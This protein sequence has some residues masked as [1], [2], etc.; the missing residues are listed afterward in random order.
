[1]P[2]PLLYLPYSVCKTHTISFRGHM[3]AGA[4]IGQTLWTSCTCLIADFHL[5]QVH[6]VHYFTSLLGCKR[7][8]LGIRSSKA[9]SDLHYLVQLNWTLHFPPWCDSF[10]QVWTHQSFSCMDQNN[11]T[12][13][14]WGMVLVWSRT[15]SFIGGGCMIQPW[16]DPTIR[17]TPASLS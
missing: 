10:G 6:S 17:H 4:V 2:K 3:M 14:L 9:F 11:C 16:S 12:E 7:C 1:M 13:T 15:N 5:D 8:K